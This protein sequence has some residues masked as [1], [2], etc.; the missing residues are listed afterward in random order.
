MDNDTLNEEASSA[1]GLSST[2]D[3]SS[4]I[5]AY[6][7]NVIQQLMLKYLSDTNFTGVTVSVTLTCPMTLLRLCAF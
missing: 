4:E 7:N 6:T 2:T 1:S 3:F 5:F